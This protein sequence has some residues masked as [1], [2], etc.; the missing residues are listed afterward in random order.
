MTGYKN[1][2]PVSQVTE[3]LLDGIMYQE[4]EIRKALKAIP[5]TTKKKAKK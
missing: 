5:K 4:D 1:K 3:I 2:K